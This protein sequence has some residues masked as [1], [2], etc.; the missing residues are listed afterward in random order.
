MSYI[1][2]RTGQQF[3]F[4]AFT[5]DDIRI[6]DVAAALSKLCRFTGHTTKFYS[7]AEHSLLVAQLVGLNGG[8][9]RDQLWGLLHDAPEAYVGDMSTPLKAYL[10]T[11]FE[12]QPETVGVEAYQELHDLIQVSLCHKLGLPETMPPVVARADFAAYT[13]EFDY[14]FPRTANVVEVSKQNRTPNVYA[15]EFVLPTIP[16]RQLLTCWHPAYAETRFLDKY[17]ELKREHDRIVEAEKKAR[18]VAE[19]SES[20]A[21]AQSSPDSHG[22]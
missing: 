16:V 6:E 15:E 8:S 17:R 5:S 19:R 2:T 12:C 14:L 22:P 7:V 11:E 9:I 18:E 1:I 10:Q 21:D 3:D 13:M 20:P 4:D